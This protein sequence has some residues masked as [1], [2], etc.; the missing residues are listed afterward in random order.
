MTPE[1]R[2]IVREELLRSIAWAGL[3]I[4]GWPILVSEL[5]WLEATPLTIFGFPVLTWALLTGGSIGVRLYTDTELRVQTPA[6]TSVSVMLGLLIGGVGAV[7]LVAVEGH[8]A[9]W[10]TAAYVTVSIGAIVWYWY[11]RLSEP[12][13]SVPA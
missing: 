8:A 13:S 3:G 11:D 7:Y 10:V 12:Q 5:G 2:P 9:L 4:V 1:L 6:G